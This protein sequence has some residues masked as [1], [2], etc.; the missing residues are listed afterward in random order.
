MAS[1]KHMA[2]LKLCDFY[3]QVQLL[4]MLLPGTQPHA[5][6]GVKLT[7]AHGKTTKRDGGLQPMV[8][9]LCWEIPALRLWI[10]SRD[11]IS[12]NRHKPPAVSCLNCRLTDFKSMISC[13]CHWVWWV[14]CVVDIITRTLVFL[15]VKIQS[16][17]TSEIYGS[18]PNYSTRGSLR[19]NK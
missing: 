11:P 12:W 17:S 14:I 8:G 1:N 2:V 16:K 10:S 18:L 13:F 6:G 3:V 4:V 5:G 7:M 19:P 9:N 15:T